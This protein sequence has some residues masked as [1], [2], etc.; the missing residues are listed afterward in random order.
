ME[1]IDMD[2]EGC[3]ICLGIE[4]EIE[5]LSFLLCTFVWKIDLRLHVPLYI[6]IW[7]V[8]WSSTNACHRTE[9]SLK[10]HMRTPVLLLLLC[11]MSTLS[12]CPDR[13]VWRELS[14]FVPLPPCTYT[15][16]LVFSLSLHVHHTWM[17]V[18]SIYR[19]SVY[20]LAGAR[21]IYL[22]AYPTLGDS[23]I[24]C[25]PSSLFLLRLLFHTSLGISSWAS[26]EESM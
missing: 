12:T 25:S 17:H 14:P 9:S 2:K 21:A 10:P 13:A 22:P 26:L 5:H 4:M 8:L 11:L 19:I 7:T 16:T 1:G 24:E 23:C 15:S 20:L 18:V 3:T 6:C